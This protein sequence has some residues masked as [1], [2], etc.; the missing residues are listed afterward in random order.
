MSDASAPP[1]PSP[2]SR[3]RPGC[4]ISAVLCVAAFILVVSAALFL[5]SRSPSAI[6]TGETDVRNR[7]RS[8]RITLGIYRSDGKIY[9]D[10]LEALIEKGYLHGM[11]RVWDPSI[12]HVVPAGRPRVPHQSTNEVVYFSRSGGYQDSGKWG[13]VNDPS[14]P[15]FGTFFID[16]TH[17]D[18]DGKA[19]TSY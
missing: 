2:E 5:H 4:L 16:C 1:A 14:D 17:T 7:L 3:N 12:D 13:Y 8:M 6:R 10:R 18:S 9:P 15:G 11:P 19:W